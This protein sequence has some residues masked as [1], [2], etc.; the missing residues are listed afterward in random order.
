[1]IRGLEE[2]NPMSQRAAPPHP[3]PAEW[4]TML[5][6]IDARLHEAMAASDVRMASL[7]Q[8]DEIRSSACRRGELLDLAALLANVTDKA[9]HAQGLA[10]DVDMALAVDEDALRR[11]LNNIQALRQRLAAWASRAI[12]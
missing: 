6:T 4:V 10:D 12:G 5:D 1:M 2:E 11:Q 7:P 8:P 9:K 3:L